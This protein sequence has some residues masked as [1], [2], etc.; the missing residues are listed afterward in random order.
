MT[1]Q[2]KDFENIKKNVL[3]VLK[4]LDSELQS[5]LGILKITICE[6]TGLK[7]KKM[8]IN[9]DQWTVTI[10]SKGEDGAQSMLHIMDLFAQNPDLNVH[11]NPSDQV[12]AYALTG[13]DP[14]VVT[15]WLKSILNDRLRAKDRVLQ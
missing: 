14:E 5:Q 8:N 13:Q 15:L 7:V 1:F 3:S 12:G 9:K 10:E 6:F 4:K 11:L 2:N